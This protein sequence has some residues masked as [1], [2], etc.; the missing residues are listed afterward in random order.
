MD[1]N[2][3]KRLKLIFSTCIVTTIVSLVHAS[4][5]L[6]SGGPREIIAAIAEVSGWTSKGVACTSTD[7]LQ[8]NLPGLCFTH[9]LQFTPLRCPN[10]EAV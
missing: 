1:H 8:L 3:R 7:V 5:I 6:I 10:L 4:F 2:L 9:G